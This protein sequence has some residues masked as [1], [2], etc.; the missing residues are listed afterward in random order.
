MILFLL[1]LVADALGLCCCWV[2]LLVL[3][4]DCRLSFCP[5]PSCLFF[6]LL[7]ICCL[8]EEAL[9]CFS[10]VVLVVGCLVVVDDR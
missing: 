1:V 7:L 2:S 4:F 3:F 8:L 6:L 9:L 10:F 5:W